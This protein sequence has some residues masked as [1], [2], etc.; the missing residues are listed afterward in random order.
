V[1]LP[2]GGPYDKWF[3]SDGTP[4]AFGYERLK[5]LDAIDS[6]DPTSLTALVNTKSAITRTI[7][8]YSGT[9]Y[10]LALTD[11]GDYCVFSN[12]AAITVT[13]PLNATVAFAIGTQIDVA[14]GGA[15]KVTFAGAGG[16]TLVSL[17]SY[18]ALSG[19]EAGGTLIKTATDTWRLHGSLTA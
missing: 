3:N 6:Y 5:L 16:V 4:T 10:T 18:K 9:T 8:A 17:S 13:I 2:V 11:A 1:R 15:G 7:N 14:Q 19:Q 12:A